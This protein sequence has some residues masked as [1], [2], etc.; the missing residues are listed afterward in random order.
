M[1]QQMISRR[2][3][4]FVVPL[5]LLSAVNAFAKAPS[6][7]PTLSAGKPALMGKML[8]PKSYVKV[9][10]QRLARARVAWVNWDYLRKAGFDIK[11]EKITPE[12]EKFI[13]DAFAWGVPAADEPKD[14][15]TKEKK[16]FY[17]DRYGGDGLAGNMGSGRAASAGEIQIKGI[18]KTDLVTVTAA[19]HSNGT[20][21]MGEALREAIYGEVG[22][23]LP[24]GANRVIAVLDRGTRSVMDDGRV[25]TNAL[26]VR[27]DPLRSA[28]YM[29]N[30]WGRGPLMESEDAR[31][32]EVLRYLEKAMPVPENLRNASPGEQMRG[33]VYGYAERIA[34]QYAA[35]YALK[36]YH[37][38][39]STSNIEITGRFIDY[40]TITTVPDY[41][42]FK[43]LSINDAVGETNEFRDIL[44]LEFLHNLRD[45]LPKQKAAGLPTDQELDDY[46]L[47]QYRL[48]HHREFL[49]LTGL[50]LDEV[51][52]IEAKES[53]WALTDL[54][55]RG[56]TEGGVRIQDPQETTR[57]TKYN[58]NKI[59]VKLASA[60]TL[61][62]GL[63]N[64]A[65]EK[66]LPNKNMRHALVKEYSR[67]LGQASFN[68]DALIAEAQNRNA[69]RSEAFRWELYKSTHQ[70]LIDYTK[71]NDVKKLG[72]AVDSV[73][74]KYRK[75]KMT[76]R[77]CIGVF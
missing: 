4:Q 74:N 30:L 37:G 31:T 59:M 27:E 52:K 51:L 45:H 38:A 18:G 76:I 46:F 8:G 72:A 71:D 39:T 34:A 40:G 47:K 26:I 67:V 36:I 20:A 48:S 22:Q 6:E 60:R 49:R 7:I 23:V 15:F 1:K 32:K 43:I 19:H 12:I 17:A 68:Q 56:A 61:N 16:T 62:E 41:G 14:A 66:D 35:A 69:E 11:E 33:A 29:K 70:Q 44:M 58:M 3:A 57:L 53:T 63:L 5:L 42:K 64:L 9:E 13:L 28:H 25:Q 75:P 73:I 10:T 50:S 2:F 24:Y 55:E 54:M 77:S 65:I 21:D